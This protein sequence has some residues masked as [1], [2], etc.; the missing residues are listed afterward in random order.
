MIEAMPLPSPLDAT[1]EEV[2]EALAPLRNDFSIALVAPGNAFAAGAI[3]RVAHSYLAREI[4]VVGTGQWYAK[5]SMGM[6]KYETIHRVTDA[7]ALREATAGRPLWVVEKD[8]ARRSLHAVE[9]FPA[10]VVFVFGSERFGVP[11]EL[12]AMADEV[13]GIPLYGVNHSLPVAVAAGIVMNEWA[14]RRY[15]AGTAL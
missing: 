7:P 11:A 3:I 6:Q 2:R 14:R 13:V 15:A 10:G 1:P 12:A 9:G 8:Q 5:A 4:F